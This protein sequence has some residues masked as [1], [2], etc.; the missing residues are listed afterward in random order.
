MPQGQWVRRLRSCPAPSSPGWELQWSVAAHGSFRPEAPGEGHWEADREGAKGKM[1]IKPRNQC[2]P[3][4]L[5]RLVLSTTGASTALSTRP[6]GTWAGAPPGNPSPRT[7]CLT[8]KQNL[9]KCLLLIFF[10]PAPRPQWGAEHCLPLP[11]G[12]SRCGDGSRELA[13]GGWSP[14]GRGAVCPAWLVEKLIKFVPFCW[15][16]F[17]APTLCCPACSAPSLR[18]PVRQMAI[19][20]RRREGT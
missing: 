4:D 14:S 12:P 17:L 11:R 7:C 16:C 10:F 13:G 19:F 5:V 8:N 9:A 15:W 1:N 20:T 2:V 6:S 3:A 18:P